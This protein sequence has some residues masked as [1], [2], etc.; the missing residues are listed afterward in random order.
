MDAVADVVVAG[1][2]DSPVSMGR[3]ERIGLTQK[4]GNFGEVFD[5]RFGKFNIILYRWQSIKICQCNRAYGGKYYLL[6]LVLTI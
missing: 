1:I 2:S 6:N 4:A 3:K 5:W